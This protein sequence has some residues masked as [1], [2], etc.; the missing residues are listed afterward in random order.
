[1]KKYFILIVIL[2]ISSVLASCNFPSSAQP[3]IAGPDALVTIAAKTVDAMATRLGSDL[4]TSPAGTPVP[5]GTVTPPPQGTTSPSLTQQASQ[6]AGTTIPCDQGA[7]VRDTTIPDGTIFL[8]GTSFTKTW[9]IKN[10]GSCAWD[11]TYAIVFGNDGDVMGGP[12]STPLVSSGTVNP[13]DTVQISVD[14]VAPSSPGTYK[15][16]W[17][18]R[19]PSGNIFFGNDKGIWVAI[20]VVSYNNR[21]SLVDNTCYADWRTSTDAGAAALP[22]P[23]KDGDSHGYVYVTNSPKFYTRGDDEPSIV[24]APQQVDNGMIVGVFPPLLV[25]SNSQF[26]TFVGCGEKMNACD[27]DVTITAQSSDGEEQTLKEWNQQPQDFNL[28]SVDLA[29]ANLANENVVFRIY[30]RANGSANQD[31]IIFLGPLVVPN[32]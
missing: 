31:K 8:P 28:I 29:A 16:Y 11:G 15:G 27:A 3:T 1:M 30:I 5:G 12:V 23:G 2:V 6:T 17:K 19:N 13:G 26:R 4:T 14:L 21:F 18:L 9:E 20:K 25:P 32:P 10:T 22:C 7:Y 24:A